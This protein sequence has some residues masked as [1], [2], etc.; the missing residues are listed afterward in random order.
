M[1]K[2]VIVSVSYIVGF[3]FTI[4][5]KNEHDR[6][7]LTSASSSYKLSSPISPPCLESPEISEVAV[8][9]MVSR[10]IRS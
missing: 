3:H 9:D 6:E 1:C 2:P 8:G 5:G 10:T 7:I 4:C